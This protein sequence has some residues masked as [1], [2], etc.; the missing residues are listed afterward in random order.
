MEPGKNISTA[1]ARWPFGAILPVGA[2]PPA[3]SAISVI[4]A[5]PYPYTGTF[6]AT[7]EAELEVENAQDSPAVEAHQAFVKEQEKAA[8]PARRGGH[9]QRGE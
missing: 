7:A 2:T 1:T 3:A 9:Q 4:Q 8:R 6:A 5:P